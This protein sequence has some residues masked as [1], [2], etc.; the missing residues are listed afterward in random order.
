[1]MRKELYRP[2]V[3]TSARFDGHGHGFCVGFDSRKAAD[4][5]ATFVLFGFAEVLELYLCRRKVEQGS[6][7]R[8]KNWMSGTCARFFFSPTRTHA[9]RL[10]VA[11][12]TRAS[13]LPA[14]GSGG[15]CARLRRA[16]GK[17]SGDPPNCRPS[18]QGLRGKSPCPPLRVALPGE[19]LA[20]GGTGGTNPRPR[21]SAGGAASVC[22]G[23]CF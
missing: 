10:Q 4:Y 3:V 15:L 2:Y 17:R 20:A 1:M 8:V 6:S 19:P 5:F 13:P 14:G 9:P 12:A 7:F 22:R 21:L 23:L 18:G 16:R 11:A